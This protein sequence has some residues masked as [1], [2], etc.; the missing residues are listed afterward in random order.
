[1]ALLAGEIFVT[2][3][4][5]EAFFHLLFGAGV[6]AF[7]IS[8]V[9]MGA[10]LVRNMRLPSARQVIGVMII[11]VGGTFGLGQ[12]LGYSVEESSQFDQ[13]V[14]LKD[15][16]IKSA[17]LVIVLARYTVLLKDRLLY[18]VPSGDII[19]FQ[20]SHELITI[21]PAAPTKE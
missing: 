16:T 21:S 1:V 2:V 5:G 6:I 19:R 15:E 9:L 10:V 18:V 17:K 7:G 12:W 20:T 3:R 13:D 4:H 14:Y 8:L 11:L